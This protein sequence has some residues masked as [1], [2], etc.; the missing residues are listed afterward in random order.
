MRASHKRLIWAFGWFLLWLIQDYLQF[1][2]TGEGFS[3]TGNTIN[4]LIWIIPLFFFED[5]KEKK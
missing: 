3:A 1:L 2:E 5:D 4:L